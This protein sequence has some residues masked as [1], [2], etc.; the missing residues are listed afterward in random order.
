MG[1]GES[2]T[3]LKK[4]KTEVVVFT[5]KT[6]LKLPE[7]RLHHDIIDHVPRYRYLGVILDHRLNWKQHCEALRGKALR[8]FIVCVVHLIYSR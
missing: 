7:L 8:N 1:S 6:S 4:K 2:S 3:I 5:R